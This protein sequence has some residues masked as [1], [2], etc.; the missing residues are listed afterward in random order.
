VSEDKTADGP[1]ARRNQSP[2]DHLAQGA[3]LALPHTA[4]LRNLLTVSGPAP[5]VARFCAAARGTGGIAWH[6]DPEDEE[7]RLLAPMA[8]EGPEARMLARELRE[9]VASLHDRVVIN[10]GQAGGCPLDL[11]RLIPIPEEILLLGETAPAA[12]RW[13]CAHWGTSRP[14]HQVRIRADQADR[15]L[16]RTARIVYEF[17]SADWTPWPAVEQLR[18]DWPRLRITIRPCYDEAADDA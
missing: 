14:L 5:E 17:L 10:C 3:P 16:R 18:N 9:V 11:N 6:L 8:T 4:W 15:R 2:Y 1:A 13:L 7:T 12:Q